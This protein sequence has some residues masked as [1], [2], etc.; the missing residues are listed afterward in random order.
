MKADVK[1]LMKEGRLEIT[2]GGW[3][4]PDEDNTNYEDMIGNF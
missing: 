2:M 4:G 1:K 3:S